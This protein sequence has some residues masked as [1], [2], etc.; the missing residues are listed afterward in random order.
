MEP[1]VEVD[2]IIVSQLDETRFSIKLA[3]SKEDINDISWS[4]GNTGD[5]YFDDRDDDEERFLARLEDVVRTQLGA[6]EDAR[7]AGDELS[8]YD[9]ELDFTY[10]FPNCV[11]EDFLA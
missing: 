8:E 2:A 1:T 6:Q 4:G 10:S 9:G 11:F 5:S 7:I 3:I